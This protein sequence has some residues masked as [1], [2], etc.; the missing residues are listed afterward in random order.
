MV[1]LV[2]SIGSFV[3]L[4]AAV[5][6]VGCG[7][8]DEGPP[9]SPEDALET[10]EVPPGFRVEI[11]AAE[12]QISDPVD[13]AFDADGK[14]YVVE[15]LDYPAESDEDPTSKVKLLEDTNGDGRYE[16]STLFAE[17]LP[18]ANGVMPWK[19]GVLVTN[20]PDIIYF[21]DTT[22]DG[23]ADVREVVL[24]GFAATNPQ[25]RMSALEYGIDN[26]IYGAYS[27]A[28]GSRRF[29]QFA[30]RGH[31][32]TFPA[33]PARDSVDIRPGNDFRFRPERFAVEPAGGMSQFGNA[34][35]ADGNR[36]AVW[37]NRHIRHVVLPHKYAARNPYLHLP[38]VMASIPEH[39]GAAT[40][41][42][43]TENPM[44]LHES[45]I[46]HFTSA[47]GHS[48]YTADKFPDGYRGNA[49]VCAP[50]H[51][52]V[53]SDRLSRK[54]GT[55]RATRP[56][57]KAEFM[58]STDRWFHPVNTAVGPDGA[59]YVADF[60]RKLVEHP[61]FIARADSQGLYTYSGKI[62]EE[63]FLEGRDKGRI[64]RVVPEDFEPG[65]KPQLSSASA[66]QLVEYLSHPNMWWRINAQRLL[67]D[68]QASAAIQP[69]R[70]AARQSTTPEGRMHALWTLE[71]LDA[72]EP[73]L[74]REALGD[75][76]PRVRRQAIRIAERYL[77]E[78]VVR[79]ALLQMGG[80]SDP[81]VQYQ[82]LLTLGELSSDESFDV[83]QQVAMRHLEDRWFRLAALTGAS[84]N[85]LD[86]FRAAAEYE[87][88]DAVRDS[89]RTAFLEQIA[90]MIGARQVSGQI[91]SL[92]TEIAAMNGDAEH[93]QIAASLDGLA[94]GL[95]RGSARTVSLTDD[96]QELLLRFL[97]NPS[98]DVQEGALAIAD[99][100]R[101]DNTPALIAL[102]QEARHRAFDES[103]DL[104]TRVN[105]ARMLG[106]VPSE[107]PVDVLAQLLSTQHQE[108]VRIAAAD[109]LTSVGTA[110]A[111][112][113]LLDHW[114]TYTSAVRDVVERSFVSTTDG[115]N[116]LLEAVESGAIEPSWI[117]RTSRGQ[118]Q[119][120]SNEEIQAT[121]D[122]LFADLGVE[123]RE[124]VIRKYHSAIQ[125]DGSVA[126][127]RTVFEQQCA[128]CH[129][130][131]E[132]GYVV[133]PD[134]VSLTNRTQIE[135]M[136]QILDPNDSI[137]PGYESYV[138]ETTDGRT[139]T[140]VLSNETASTVVIRST[141]GIEETIRRS[142]IEAMR[143]SE[144]SLMPVGL[145]NSISVEQMADLLTYLQQ[146]E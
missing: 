108:E 63:D 124:Q 15:M 50:V 102:R 101:L 118:L 100:V 133:G 140:G 136:S 37:N 130:I 3:L 7:S 144:V 112:T 81:Q 39:G 68:R 105:A 5:V 56:R 128:S 141:G 121:A 115:A 120:S 132:T 142:N 122:R 6:F 103:A 35:D 17:D 90:G 127:G 24:T 29:P 42:P 46:G 8:T 84:D 134:L 126:D 74:V 43:I 62:T 99:R 45:E 25:L 58:A 22:G 44:H 12:P 64:Y 53:H 77:D 67:V 28:G 76:S 88:E 10:I 20:A 111:N 137:A 61:T 125:M 114:E 2:R 79:T 82:L 87:P 135:L 80:D 66:E 48:I 106:L 26:W 52:V 109:V 30:D 54:G 123:N 60:Y 41:Y 49:Y 23:R 18:F 89:G 83:L 143:P 110:E 19:D 95:G 119:R 78:S 55:F 16:T 91:G 40:L 116:R 69:L 27:R 11:A 65:E 145:E 129:R 33:D 32:L 36:F 34:F 97:A 31:P 96:A 85:G 104:N 4:L 98:L 92:L 107:A 86:W 59:L 73:S 13:L 21:E 51:N 70:E 9:Y 47:C 75:D 94:D 139:I 38:S 138:V 146:L 131:G 1:R 71:G 117:S 57:E 14:L 93:P 72:M 113:V